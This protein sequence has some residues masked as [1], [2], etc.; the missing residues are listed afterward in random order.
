MP[1]TYT[2][3]AKERL[4]RTQ[5]VGDVTLAEVLAHFRELERDPNSPGR[6]DVFLDLSETT[7]LPVTVQIAA[8]A[9]EIKRIRA[10]VRFHA[11]AVVAQ[12]DALFGMLRMLEVKAEPFFHAFCVFRVSTEAETWLAAQRLPMGL[13][14]EITPM[15]NPD[16]Q[17]GDSNPGQ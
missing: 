17:S 11:C 15:G 8:V 5:C 6:V 2:L 9:D 4:I 16:Q 14:L 1:V 13:P 10:K 7:S 3:D 12:R